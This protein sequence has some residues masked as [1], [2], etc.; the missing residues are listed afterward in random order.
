MKVLANTKGMSEQEWLELRKN[1]LGGSDASVILGVNKYKSAVALYLEK[2]GQIENEFT[3]NLATE[4]GNELEPFVAKKFEEATGKRVRR[5]NKM[6]QHEEHE[7]MTANLDRV[8]I[9]EKAFLECKTT[10][11]R[12]ENAWKDDAVPVEYLAQ[13]MHYLAVTGYERAYIAVVIGNHDFQYKVIERDEDLINTIIEKEKDF[14]YNNVKAGVMPTIDGSGSTKDALNNLYSEPIDEVMQLGNDVNEIIDKINVLKESIALDKKEV[15]RLE[16]ILREK[17]GNHEKA[18][19]ETYFISNKQYSKNSIDSKKLKADYPE[20]AAQCTKQST[21][22]K[23]YI[24]GA[25]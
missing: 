18:E 22:K 19:S 9:G 25:N 12:N 13:V 7:F 6:L 21:Y 4:L 8:I 15:G 5:L 1:Y 10:N 24:K 14:Y 17:L 2:T 16:N 11:A 3:G 20:I 23:L